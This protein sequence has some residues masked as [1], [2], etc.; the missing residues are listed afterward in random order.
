MVDSRIAAIQKVESTDAVEI[1]NRRSQGSEKLLSL[2]KAQK[3]NFLA[4]F[5]D[6]KNV[7]VF[8]DKVLKSWAGIRTVVITRFKAADAGEEA[9]TNILASKD[10]ISDKEFDQG[11]G[12][13]LGC[14]YRG[15]EGS[16]VGIENINEFFVTLGVFSD[17]IPSLKVLEDCSGLFKLEFSFNYFILSDIIVTQ[18]SFQVQMIR[19]VFG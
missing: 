12:V 3:R 6:F 7:L 8:S 15:H 4:K 2:T 10:I 11:N 19:I 5:A 9:F 14:L 18:A 17:R 13:L 1:G 16:W